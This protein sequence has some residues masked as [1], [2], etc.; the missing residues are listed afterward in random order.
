M[1]IKLLAA[2]AVLAGGMGAA[3]GQ[4]APLPLAGAKAVCDRGEWGHAL[5]APQVID[6]DEK[7][8]WTSGGLD[9]R[10]LPSNVFLTLPQ[11]VAVGSIEVLTVVAKNTLRLSDLEVYT[12]ADEG[13]A[14]L[15]SVKGN[16]SVRFRV[17]LRPARVTQLRLRVLDNADPRHAWA[18]ILEVRLFPA[19]EGAALEALRPAP[20][21]KEG[22]TERLFVT[23][24]LG[25]RKPEPTTAYDP[26]KAYLGY[27][28]SF[29]DTMIAH[30][31]DRYGKERSPLFVSLLET[32]TR[33]HPNSVLP[34]I[35]GQRIGD[36]AFYG[37][38][39]QHDMMLLQTC[40]YL[41]R[42]TSEATYRDAARKYVQFFLDRCAATPTGLWPWGEHAHWDVY[43]E[44][45]GHYLHEYLGAAPLEFWEQAWTLNPRALRG[46][47]DGL[48]NH[49]KDLQTFAFCRHA[50]INQVLPDPRPQGLKPLDFPRHGGMYLQVWAFAYSK[51]KDPK[52][53]AWSE[54][55]LKYFEGTRRQDGFLPV[56]SQYSARPALGPAP[57][58]NLS[59]GITLLESAPLLGDV[60]TAAHYRALGGQLLKALAGQPSDLPKKLG[61][62]E[63][64]GGGDFGGDSALMRVQAYRLTGDHAHLDAAR[65]HARLYAEAQQLPETQMRAHVFGTLVNLMLDLHE[66]DKGDQWLPAA[67]R[68]ARWGIERLYHNGL[69]RGATN[70]WYYDS[71][72]GVSAF[73]YGLVRLHAATNKTTVSVP[74][75]RFTR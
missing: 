35:P 4:D 51:T 20:V 39:L 28:R 26:K 9:L 42:L 44:A 7:T 68:Y 13:W 11:P 46:E 45:T 1:L 54:R 63:A 24:A 8:L 37:S 30:G 62:T 56:L 32:A 58:S 57:G 55:L 49:V 2:A 52:Y 38:N 70:L 22:V 17:P 18:N 23:E 31:T 69:F 50:D 61:F 74:P 71:E 53:L 29:A 5:P 6:G 47:A 73:A 67:E 3:A 21:R 41:S 12:R 36:R 14:L 72:L 64:Y 16:E 33:K 19:P 25:L 60:P 75:F 40:E 59:V 10:E 15:G 65:D 66:L 27:V 43:K 34:S 48:I